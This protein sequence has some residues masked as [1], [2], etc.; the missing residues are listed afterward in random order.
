MET[1]QN[2]IHFIYCFYWGRDAVQILTNLM[3]NSVFDGTVLKNC[4]LRHNG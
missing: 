2:D 3:K 4:L 1:E